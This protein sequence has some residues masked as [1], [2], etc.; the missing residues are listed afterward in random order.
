M[1]W[2]MVTCGIE[3][4]AD[5][6][7]SLNDDSFW[8]IRTYQRQKCGA[9]RSIENLP[10]FSLNPNTPLVRNTVDKRNFLFK[11]TQH[12]ANELK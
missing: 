3:R 9:P 10:R 2:E 11:H 7:R 6:K 5:G 12:F 4:V 1:A 8:A